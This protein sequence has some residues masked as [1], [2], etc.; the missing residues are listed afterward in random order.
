MKTIG[1]LGG[2]SWLSTASY[3]QAINE[4]INSR[5]GAAHSARLILH[6]VNFEDMEQYRQQ[7]DWDSIARE[8]A[9]AA[10]GLQNSGANFWLLCTNTMHKLAPAIEDQ[11][12]IPLLHIADATGT[13]IQ[14][15]GIK[16]VGL[17]GTRF[18]MSEDFYKQRLQDKFGI[19]VLVPSTAQQDRIHEV[20]YSELVLGKIHD[21]SREDYQHT[22]GALQQQGAEGIILGCTEIG[23]LLKPEHCSVA[24]FDTA[25]IH[26]AE[27]V[28]WALGD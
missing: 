27:A 3:Y 18:T 26:A 5:L 8:L 17:L 28:E 16:K 15:A 24:L 7:N 13:A 23:L 12:N 22:V 25:A 11:L 10:L 21:S 20:I 14:K 19:E 4:G 1:L 9:A 2:L 6:S